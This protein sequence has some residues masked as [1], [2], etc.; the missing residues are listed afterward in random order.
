M[1]LV[2]LAVLQTY[3][4]YRRNRLIKQPQILARGR[5]RERCVLAHLRVFNHLLELVEHFDL[6][7][8]VHRSLLV[9]EL[10]PVFFGQDAVWVVIR[11]VTHYRLTSQSSLPPG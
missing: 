3:I 1:I 5:W 6:V 8:D 2:P 4:R 11:T 10:E 7:V 9:L